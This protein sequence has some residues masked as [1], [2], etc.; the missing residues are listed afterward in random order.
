VSC[1][2]AARALCVPHQ[3]NVVATPA[4]PANTVRRDKIAM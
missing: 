1:G 4:A 2:T 3:P